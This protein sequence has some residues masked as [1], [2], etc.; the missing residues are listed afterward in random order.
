MLFDK[1]I[2]FDNLKQKIVIIANAPKIGNAAV[3]LFTS[4]AGYFQH[5][6]KKASN[7]AAEQ[8]ALDSGSRVGKIKKATQGLLWTVRLWSN[9][10]TLC[11]KQ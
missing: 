5:V 6:M 9:V 7:E 3:K 8:F 2:A 4:P 1:V 11:W 10:H